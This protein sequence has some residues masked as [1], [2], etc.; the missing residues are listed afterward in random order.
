MVK[1]STITCSLPPPGSGFNQTIAR[2]ST[3]QE[4]LSALAVFAVGDSNASTLVVELNSNITLTPANTKSLALPLEIGSG[5]VVWRSG[6]FAC[7]RAG[8]RCSA[9]WRPASDSRA[10]ACLL[11]C[12]H[13]G[14]GAMRSLDFGG[15]QDLMFFDSGTRLIVDGLNLSGAPPCRTALAV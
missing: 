7:R 2:V 6:E 1:N 11:T 15:T 5:E 3:A 12:T 8:V 14:R 4:F 10:L 9:A 13:T